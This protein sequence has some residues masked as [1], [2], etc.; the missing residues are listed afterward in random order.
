MKK[1]RTKWRTSSPRTRPKIR[2]AI[3]QPSSRFPPSTLLKTFRKTTLASKKKQRVSPPFLTPISHHHPPATRLSLSL[4]QGSPTSIRSGLTLSD[5]ACVPK[6]FLR[7]QHGHELVFRAKAS[8]SLWRRRT[9]RRRRRRPVQHE[10]DSG[11]SRV[12]DD[13]HDRPLRSSPPPSLQRIRHQG[14]VTPTAQER[15]H[16]QQKK[17][18]GGNRRRRRRQQ[19]E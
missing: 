6:D 11:Q 17:G 9:R 15:R 10:T 2:R 8:R 12:D 13:E 16:R 1:R 5:F 3:P 7:I 4:F 14:H 19:D 18:G